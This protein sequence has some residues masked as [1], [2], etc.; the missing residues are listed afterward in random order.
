LATTQVARQLLGSTFA[1][2][3]SIGTS[4]SNFAA[5]VNKITAAGANAI[6]YAAYED[7]MVPFIK[8][9]RAAKPNITIVSG[10]WGYDDETVAE[11]GTAAEGIYAT[12][13]AFPP[14]MVT[15]TFLHDV[16]ASIADA[17]H[18]QDHVVEAYDAA[19]LILAGLAAGKTNRAAMLA[20]VNAYNGRGLTGPIRFQHNGNRVTVSVWVAQVV[21]GS[22]KTIGRITD[23]E[24][25]AN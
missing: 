5:V 22:W 4:D 7:A 13:P 9:L 23:G 11:M 18:D 10:F 20:W 24:P 14:S 16:G 19:N 6:Y 8:Q 12:N 1:G 17:V 21:D 3:A 15:G 2:S 25:A